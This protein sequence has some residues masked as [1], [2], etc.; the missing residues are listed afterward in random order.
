MLST[1]PGC[2][3]SQGAEMYGQTTQ[4]RAAVSDESPQV[5]E[6]HHAVVQRRVRRRVIRLSNRV[7]LVAVLGPT[8]IVV[9]VGALAYWGARRERATRLA[10]ENKHGSIV[11]TERFLTRLVDAETGQRGYLL[12]GREEY[13]EPYR[14][15]KSD[16]QVQLSQ[17]QQRVEKDP[18]QL[19]RL[20]SLGVLVGAIFA[21]LEETIALRRT[22]PLDTAVQVIESDRGKRAMDQSRG[23]VARMQARELAQLSGR[24]AREDRYSRLSIVWLVAG[25]LICALVSVLVNGWLDRYAYGQAELAASLERANELLRA[26]HTEL[27]MQND[28]LQ[29]LGEELEQRTEAAESANRAKAA[30]LAAMS[31]DVRTPLNAILGYV[32]L[33]ALGIRGSITE[34]QRQDLQR[35]RTSGQRLLALINDI[36]SFASIEAGKID[37]QMKPVNVARI[38]RELE[39][40]FLPQVAARG[41]R[42]AFRGCEPS[43]CVEADPERM[44]QIL[45][46]LVTN[47]IKFTEPHGA[48]DVS[49]M[50]GDER[51]TIQVSDTGHGIPA[52]KLPTIFEPFV[53]VDRSRTASTQQ[54]V[55]LGLAIS[56]ELA[57]GMNGELSVASVVGRGSCFSLELRRATTCAAAGPSSIESTLGG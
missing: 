2:Q 29:V 7:R 19:A 48:I 38:I 42:Y 22:G 57:R 50:V 3:P 17:L 21:E 32:D 6:Q 43:L 52:E 28:Q 31:H 4:R 53:Q 27:E 1:T 36:L 26:Q 56:R 25:T 47:A 45:L 40:S 33:L 13:L 54:G 37:I 23:I 5:D 49:C 8:L 39:A 16:V 35:I 46:N 20:D 24:S 14:A 10:V 30:F 11:S 44:G 18:V 9:L 15:A 55:G 41:L 51:V 34:A 12:T